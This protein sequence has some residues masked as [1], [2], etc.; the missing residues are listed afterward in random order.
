MTTIASA[1]GIAASIATAYITYRMWRHGSG[2]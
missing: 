1:L 2:K